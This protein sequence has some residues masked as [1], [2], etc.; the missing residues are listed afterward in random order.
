MFPN[1]HLFLLKPAKAW[2]EGVFRDIPPSQVTLFKGTH[3]GKSV[4]LGHSPASPA[5]SHYQVCWSKSL[6]SFGHPAA[7]VYGESGWCQEQMTSHLALIVWPEPAALVPAPA[8]GMWWVPAGNGSGALVPAL[9]MEELPPTT[10]STSP[11]QLQTGHRCPAK[12]WPKC[13]RKEGRGLTVKSSKHK[14]TKI[15]Y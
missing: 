2:E 4:P 13:V 15:K 8:G 5:H 11:P 9:G 10:D 6:S 3:W 7:S 1:S 12:T 14:F